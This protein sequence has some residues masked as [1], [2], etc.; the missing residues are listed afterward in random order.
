MM[1]YSG[2]GS[3]VWINTLNSA[4][5]IQSRSSALD[6]NGNVI[7]AG[8]FLGKAIFGSGLADIP[9]VSNGGSDIFVLKLNPKGNLI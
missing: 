9:I 1:C 5:S 6:A 4:A 3:L 8:R 7:V 2:D